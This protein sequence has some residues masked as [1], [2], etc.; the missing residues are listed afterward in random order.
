M[1]TFLTQHV[2]WP[3][4]CNIVDPVCDQGERLGII[5]RQ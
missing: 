3:I 2:D 5:M 4:G 1:S